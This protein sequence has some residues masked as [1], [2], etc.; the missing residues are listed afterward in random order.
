MI[1]TESHGPAHRL[2]DTVDKVSTLYA[3]KNCQLGMS[4]LARLAQVHNSDISSYETVNYFNN[5]AE[6]LAYLE[7]R[8][9]EWE[10]SP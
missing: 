5:S 3:M 6:V 4:V 8:F 7:T 1:H 9:N 10:N 2:E